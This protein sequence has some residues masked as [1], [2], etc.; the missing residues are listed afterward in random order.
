MIGQAVFLAHL[1]A[2]SAGA[3]GQAGCLLA[4]LLAAGAGGG[5]HCA[6][7]HRVV[8]GTE[9]RAH[10]VGR[11]TCRSLAHIAAA[12]RRMATGRAAMAAVSV[13]AK[14][15]RHT[16][17]AMAV[18]AACTIARTRMFATVCGDTAMKTVIMHRKAACTLK[19]RKCRLLFHVRFGCGGVIDLPSN[20]ATG[21]FAV[22]PFR[23]ISAAPRNFVLSLHRSGK[24]TGCR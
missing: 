3:F 24:W 18:Q 22:L 7:A 6:G 4:T 14:R 20:F 21:A 5:R 19:R 23:A 9:R 17:G 8:A 13:C 1:S 16:V 15:C 12:P 2:G 10:A 11:R